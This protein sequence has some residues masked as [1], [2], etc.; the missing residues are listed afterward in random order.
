MQ[1]HINYIVVTELHTMNLFNVNNTL[2]VKYFSINCSFD[3]LIWI[4]VTFNFNFD[5][6]IEIIKVNNS[7]EVTWIGILM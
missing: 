6:V 3:T 5:I 7:S 1:S 4:G 2:H